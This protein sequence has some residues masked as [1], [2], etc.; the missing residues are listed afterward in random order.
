M[1]PAPTE[2]S[3]TATSVESSQT[4]TPSI[5]HG[6]PEFQQQ[7]QSHL[8]HGDVRVSPIDRPDDTD[9]ASTSSGGASRGRQPNTG[10]ISSRNG[11]SQESSPG[12]RIDE[13]E[14]AHATVR[15][16][17]D[18]MIFQVVPNSQS[19]NVSIQEFPN[20]MLLVAL[21]LCLLTLLQRS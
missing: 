20:G 4:T 15:K 16:P 3:Q 14:R 21:C 2:A 5:Q 19:T 18:G 9:A 11:S 6:Q 8:F 13:Y 1:Q 12:S 17:S 10:R 7:T